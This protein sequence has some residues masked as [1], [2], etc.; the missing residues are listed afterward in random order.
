MHAL[1]V[2]GY[3]RYNTTKMATKERVAYV[4]LAS[5]KGYQELLEAAV[6]TVTAT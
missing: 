5:S 4:G 1:Y 2:R 6:V 3:Q